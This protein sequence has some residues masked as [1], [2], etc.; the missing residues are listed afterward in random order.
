MRSNIEE[1]VSCV[2]KL[3]RAAWTYNLHAPTKHSVLK[4]ETLFAFYNTKNASLN[5]ADP[6]RVDGFVACNNTSF[7]YLRFLKW[8]P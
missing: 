7:V 3:P 8:F 2:T 6:S 1:S 4:G 5:L